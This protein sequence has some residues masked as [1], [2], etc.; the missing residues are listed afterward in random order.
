MAT[1]WLLHN[2]RIVSSVL[3]ASTLV[4]TSAVSAK[5]PA[6]DSKAHEP[7]APASAEATGPLTLPAVLALT[8]TQ[9]P[10]LQQYSWQ[11]R[12][13][14]AG[15]LQAG[16]R[17]NPRADLLVED[18]LGT[19]EFRG[20]RHAQVTLALGQLIE[21]GG[22]RAARVAVASRSRDVAQQEYEA[23]RVDVLADASERFLAVLGRQDARALARTST[24]LTEA[25]LETVQERVRAG[26]TS[27]LEAKKAQIGLARA[28]VEEEDALHELAVAR[29]R[30]AAAWGS[31]T[32]SFERAEGDL[33]ARAPIPAFPDLAR[34]I[35]DS[36]DVLRRISEEGLRRAE[37][38]LAYAKRI[39]DLNLSFGP[40]WLQE[41]SEVSFLFGVAAPLPLFDRNQG[42][43]AEARALAGKTTASRKSTEIRLQAALF[44]FH[45]ELLHAEH[46]LGA[47][48][49][50]I[51]PEAEEALSLSRQGFTQGRLSYLEL[52][53]AQRTF[54]D[55]KAEHLAAAA[56]YHHLVLAIERLTGEPLHREAQVR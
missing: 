12:A 38:D 19:G 15:I 14:E 3:L 11:V 24:E 28:R 43:R 17:P 23:E 40:R 26:A 16:L 4:C 50:Q 13:E 45:Q 52:L 33:F 1:P 7:A 27:S 44:E 20:G 32:P 35:G 51:L 36:P 18:V 8:L 10:R 55:L 53:D 47:L 6:D 39:P 2:L 46:V 42:G 31:T 48:E 25:T 49:K 5:G 41:P 21:L 9:S 30:L 22:K 37:L 56:S 34:R 29:S 54:V